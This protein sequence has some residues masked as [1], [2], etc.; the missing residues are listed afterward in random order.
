MKFA[1]YLEQTQ[2]PE[3]KRA[4]IDYRGLKKKIPKGTKATESLLKAEPEHISGELGDVDEAPSTSRTGHSAGE[5]LVRKKSFTIRKRTV[6]ETLVPDH[7]ASTQ[8]SRKSSLSQLGRA[9]TRKSQN[10]NSRGFLLEETEFVNTLDK[11]LEKV[12]TFYGARKKHF[13]ARSKVLEAQLIELSVHHERFH[14][15]QVKGNGWMNILVF[16]KKPYAPKFDAHTHHSRITVVQ[17]KQS[18]CP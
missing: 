1:K 7:A 12:E 16:A 11:E 2:T 15:A 17:K 9:M 13:E 6:S 14:E 10:Q 18:T 8:A 4:Y 5:L 3:W